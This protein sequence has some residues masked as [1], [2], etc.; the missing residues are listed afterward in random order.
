[1]ALRTQDVV[2]AASAHKIA[3]VA[4][5]AA[6]LGGGGIATVQVASSHHHAPHRQRVVRALTKPAPARPAPPWHPAASV[7]PQPKPAKRAKPVR[8]QP[9]K[10]APA[11][12]PAEQVAPPIEPAA[13]VPAPAPAP[14]PTAQEPSGQTGEFGP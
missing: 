10:P 1:M 11:T 12:P 2:E 9:A 7:A 3:A 8:K 14:A 13:G 6:A 5:S 4:A